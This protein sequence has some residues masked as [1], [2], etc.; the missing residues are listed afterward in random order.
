MPSS[1]DIIHASGDVSSSDSDNPRSSADDEGSSNLELDRAAEI[2]LPFRTRRNAPRKPTHQ[3]KG[4]YEVTGIDLK[5]WAPT[6]IVGR[7]RLNMQGFRKADTKTRQRIVREIMNHF[8]RSKAVEKA[9]GTR[10]TE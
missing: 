6:T 9:G 10:C 1:S 3:P 4:I 2:T 8:K 5:S 7:A